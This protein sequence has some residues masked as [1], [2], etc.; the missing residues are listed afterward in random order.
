MKKRIL[1]LITVLMMFMG[2]VSASSINGDYKGNPIVKVYSKGKEIKSEVP[3]MIYDGNTVV[4]ISVLKQLGA[5]VKWDA[6]T[7]S[8]DVNMTDSQYDQKDIKVLKTYSR[9]AEEYRRLGLLGDDVIELK[10]YFS[11]SYQAIV[12][13]HRAGENI[14]LSEESLKLSERS[15]KLSNDTLE[16]VSKSIN[17]KIKEIEDV[18]SLASSLN[19][20]V[21]DMRQ[22]NQQYEDALEQYRLSYALI[23]GFSR[24]E[25]N[26][27]NYI[28][29]ISKGAEIVEASQKKSK[30]KYSEFYFKIQLY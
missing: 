13:N 11:L 24:N 17:R 1:V 23:E 5:T 25:S 22:M 4:P 6:D 9:I 10:R 2:V 16:A 18:I 20:D 27:E 26:A 19:I 8:V 30:V 29:F 21:T 15:L 28:D 7:Y 3:A 12:M 14:K